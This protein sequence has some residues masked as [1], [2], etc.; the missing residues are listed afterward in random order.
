MSRTFI[1]SNRPY[2]GAIGGSAGVNYRTLQANQEYNL[3]PNAYS[4]FSNI[5]IRH[6]EPLPSIL[7]QKIILDKKKDNVCHKLLIKM[8]KLAALNII[9]HKKM[10]IRY[11]QKVKELNKKYS[12]TND[13]FFIFHDIESAFCFCNIIESPNTLLVYHQQ[14]SLYSEW[15]SFTRRKG[16]LYK[17]YLAKFTERVFEK[18]KTIGFPSW[19]AFK[20]LTKT[21]P[22]LNTNF[23]NKVEIFY[24]GINLGEKLHEV[25]NPDILK[26]KRST[27]LK[28][29]T[30]AALNE[31][32]AVERIPQFLACLKNYKIDFYWILIGNGPKSS[33]VEKEIKEKGLENNVFWIKSP[34]PHNDILKVFESSDFYILFHKYSIFDYATLEAMSKCNIPILSNIGGNKEVITENNGFLI[35]D[36]SNADIIINFIKTNKLDNLKLLNKQIVANKFSS[37]AFLKAYLDWEKKIGREREK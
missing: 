32:K 31:A 6:D 24:N 37:Y 23:I 34:V 22:S 15:Q 28:F 5:I 16:K 26:F 19:G 14:G 3:I 25:V 11:K 21:E 1:I 36:Y 10:L 7:E 18:V 12:F 20:A 4:I 8:D 17:A 2:S 30:V 29:S 33:E 13:D 27:S 35:D 9:K